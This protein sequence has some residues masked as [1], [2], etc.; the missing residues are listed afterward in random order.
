M[1]LNIQD[2]SSDI[3]A[4]KISEL[5]LV[6]MEGGSYVIHALLGEKS[7]PVKDA[8]G[9][10]LHIA[11]VEEARKVLSSVPDVHL[12]LRQGVPHDEMVGLDDTPAESSRHE[13]PLR[14]S[15]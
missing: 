2:L 6:S 1:I 11:S 7:V 4:G 15:L 14:S 3:K 12:F 9:K 8:H 10:P 13:I 5:N